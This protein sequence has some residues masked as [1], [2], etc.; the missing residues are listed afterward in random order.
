[1]LC[2]S[3]RAV[4]LLAKAGGTR[5]L[6]APAGPNA[7]TPLHLAVLHN[8]P[9]TVQALLSAGAVLVAQAAM[10]MSCTSNQ[11]LWWYTQSSRGCSAAQTWGPQGQMQMVAA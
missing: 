5:S 1:M 3:C 2:V 9:Q 8:H 4:E 7:Y 10:C 6:Q 11:G